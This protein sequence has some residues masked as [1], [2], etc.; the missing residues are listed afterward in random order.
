MKGAEFIGIYHPF[1]CVRDAIRGIILYRREED[2][3]KS[4][5]LLLIFYLGGSIWKRPGRKDILRKVSL[6]LRKDTAIVQRCSQIRVKIIK[7]LK[8]EISINELENKIKHNI[9]YKIWKNEE[10]EGCN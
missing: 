7:I 5:K 1:S 3:M 6:E 8:K 10:S 2:L 9:N 4:D